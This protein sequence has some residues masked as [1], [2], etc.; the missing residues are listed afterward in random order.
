MKI[1]TVKG[2]SYAAIAHS[3]TLVKVEVFSHGVMTVHPFINWR[4]G[5]DYYSAMAALVREGALLSRSARAL[6]PMGQPVPH[7]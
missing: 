7:C 5:M 2:G 3:F 1:S 4:S 6:H